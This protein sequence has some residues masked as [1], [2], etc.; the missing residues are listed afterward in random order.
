MNAGVKEQGF[1]LLCKHGGILGQQGS[2]PLQAHQPLYKGPSSQPIKD[3][4]HRPGLK[5]VAN[6]SSPSFL[7]LNTSVYSFF[8]RMD[9]VFAGWVGG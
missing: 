1:A 5:K 9:W 4:L 6:F 3:D 2:P 7:N 8:G